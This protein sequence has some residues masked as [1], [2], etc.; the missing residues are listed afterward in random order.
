MN[1]LMFGF[2]TNRERNRG[3]RIE[4]LEGEVGEVEMITILGRHDWSSCHAI[5]SFEDKGFSSVSYLSFT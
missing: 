3:S 5:A 4:A 1:R 2:Q